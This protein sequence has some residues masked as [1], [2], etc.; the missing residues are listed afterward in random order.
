VYKRQYLT[1]IAKYVCLNCNL[2][3]DGDPRWRFIPAGN[4]DGEEML[5]ASV[6]GDPHGKVFSSRGRGWG[7][8]PRWGIPRC[9]PYFR[10][11][12]LGVG[13]WLRLII[14]SQSRAALALADSLNL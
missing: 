2:N 3:G 4:G 5:P 11:S 13:V 7:A 10:G 12:G 1:L 9:H 14:G 6:R 8:I